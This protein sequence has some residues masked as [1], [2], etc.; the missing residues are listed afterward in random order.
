MICSSFVNKIIGDHLITMEL[1]I[2]IYL[3]STNMLN[4]IYLILFALT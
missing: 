2:L 1:F 3:T 4:N